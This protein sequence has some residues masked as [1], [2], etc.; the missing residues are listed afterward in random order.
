MQNRLREAL[1][2]G[3]FVVSCELVAGRG[4]REEHQQ[5]EVEEALRIA[6]T[7][8][9]QAISITDNPGGNPAL[10]ADA[11]AREF[12]DAGVTPLVHMTCKDRNRNQL[13]S[14]FYAL[15]RQG[16]ENLLVMTGDYPS[17]GWGG[18]ARPVF[19]LD[20]VQ[21]LQMITEMNAGLAQQTPRGSVTE[22]PTAFFAGAVASPFK[23]TEAETLLQYLKLEKKLAAGAQF[24]ISQVGYDARKMAELLEYLRQRRLDVPVIANVFVLGAGAGR[25]MH[26]GDFP[27]CYVSDELLGV[28][29]AEAAAEDKGREAKLLRAARMVAIARG[30][31]YQGVHLGGM[32]LTAE[33]ISQ[34]LAQA[35]ELKD[36]WQDWASELSYGQPGGFY[37]FAEDGSPAPRNEAARGRRIF[38]GYG[39]SRCFHYWVLT[40]GK[41][42]YKPL[43]AVMDARERA[44][45]RN[46]HHGLEHLA[47]VAL[48]GCRDCGDCGLE[49]CVYSCPMSQCPKCQRNGPC[50]GSRE[51]FC[52]VYP[53]ERYC[54]W[55]KA[56]HRLKRYGQLEQLSAWITE[57]NDWGLEAT[58]GWSNYTHERDNAAKRLYLSKRADEPPG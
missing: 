27:G 44:R 57:P 52:E 55:Y 37:L 6:A 28:L 10:L 12:A 13:Q 48:Y 40:K 42:G 33:V 11:L 54:I 4:A 20:P 2:D 53:G 17:S 46:R 19:D 43:S 25:L 14:Q 16:I 23:W 1:A 30:Q 51:G 35:D 26:R 50:G 5:R 45:G 47:K 18:Q 24:I 8:R 32:G 9:V 38:S 22:Q 49:T 7:G 36:G 58:S 41:R 3:E 29:E 34:I 39:L 56:Y 15:A 31:G 21:L